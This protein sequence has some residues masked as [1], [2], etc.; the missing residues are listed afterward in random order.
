[1]NYLINDI[2]FDTDNH[3]LSYQDQKVFL[4]AKSYQLLQTFLNQQNKTLSRDD[5][6]ELAWHGQ[7]VS[8]GAVNKAVSKLRNH[9]ELLSPDQSFIQTKPKFGYLFCASVQTLPSKNGV[10]QKRK[11]TT[12]S[13]LFLS[14]FAIILFAVV[15][16]SAFF[17]KET[18]HNQAKHE[19]YSKL[20]RYSAHDGVETHLSNAKNGDLLYLNQ[21]QEDKNLFIKKV[22]GDLTKLSLPLSN[23]KNIRL[24]PSG[25]TLA[26]VSQNDQQCKVYI[27][28]I[29]S[30]IPSEKFECT[31]F[32]DLKLAWSHDEQSLFI[33]ARE[34]NATPYSIYQLQLATQVLQQVSL[35]VGLSDLKGDFLLATHPNKPLLAFARYLES[36]RSEIHIINTDNLQTKRIHS[37]EHTLNAL[38]WAIDDEKLYISN[39]KTLSVLA[40]NE[41]Q[42]IKYFSYPIESLA[43]TFIS[44]Q[45][46]VVATQYHPSTKIKSYNIENKTEHTLYHNAALNRL[47]RELNNHGLLFISDMTQTHSLWFSNNSGLTKIELPFEFG[48]RRFDI[49]NDGQDIIFEHHGA[50]YEFNF[51]KKA[52]ST[53]FDG[54]HKAYVANYHL[55]H[56][57]IIYSSNK[58]GQWQLWEFQKSSQQH[59]Q[60]TNSGGYSGYAYKNSLIYSKRNQDGLWKKSDDE[61]TLLI[62]NFKNINWLNW[63]IVDDDVFF[64]RPESGVWKFNLNTQSEEL[65][66]P[67]KHGFIHQYSMSNDA[68]D[69]IFVELQPLQGDIQ[70]LVLNK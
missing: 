69:I 22:N 33:Q 19:T 54:A 9:F 10:S 66:M 38:T 46:S 64:Y 42:I 32:S 61:E 25:D 44:N 14:I 49:S 2:L 4:E 63:Q 60:L 24:S 12:N 40:E 58:T 67:R 62:S 17:D 1:M 18:K 34:S 28:P 56:D 70:V 13:A 59:K 47:P 37:L 11:S 41:E 57:A 30:M 16:G 15:L 21:T 35:P 65:L 36:D 26:Y 8:D 29:S 68:K 7:V 31:Q 23:I 55:N 51:V 52:V 53:L 45:S 20:V 6:I 39:Q 48:F 43:S 3:S 50:I 5:L 27:A